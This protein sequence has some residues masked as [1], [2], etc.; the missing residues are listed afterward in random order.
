MTLRTWDDYPGEDKAQNGGVDLKV[1][2]DNNTAYTDLMAG[3]LDLVD[4]V[5]ASQLR[6]VKNDL[7]DRYLNT[8]AG[9]IQTLAFPFYE[10]AWD[11]EDA[12]K[13]RQGAAMAIDRAQITDPPIFQKTRTPASDW[14]SRCSARRAASRKGCASASST[15]PRRRS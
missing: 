5:P 3:N 4:D 15:R 7:G 6:N 1:Y 9:I 12:R 2:T 8:P 13:V 14:T 10:E 11:T